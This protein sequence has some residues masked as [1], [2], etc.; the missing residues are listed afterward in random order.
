MCVVTLVFLLLAV[1][2]TVLPPSLSVPVESSPLLA[3]SFFL[4]AL[5][6]HLKHNQIYISV[7]QECFM[8]GE[9]VGGGGEGGV[10]RFRPLLL[11][12]L[13]AVVEWRVV[14]V[15]FCQFLSEIL[16]MCE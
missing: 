13:W 2:A 1:V 6:A 8:G 9:G 7:S 10:G 11:I 3:V 5:A 15:F 4:A 16:I 14:T 12:I